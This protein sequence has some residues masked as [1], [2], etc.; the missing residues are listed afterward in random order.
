MSRSQ[1]DAHLDTRSSRLSR[2]KPRKA[3]YWSSL[4]VGLQ[5]GYFR[6]A[7]GPGT[8]RARFYSADTRCRLQT[9]LGTADD[10]AD[11]DGVLSFSFAQAQAKAREWFDVAHQQSTGEVIHRGPFT[12]TQAWEAYR[13]DCERRGIKSMDR[14]I[15]AVKLHILP[16]LGRIEVTKLT[17]LH[18]ERWH[19]ALA[20]ES[21]RM[22]PKAGEKEAFR[23][24]P[25][26]PNEVRAR[27]DSANRVLSI[28]KAMLSHAKARRLTQA[29][30]E[31]WRETRPFKGTT[32][33]RIRF[34]D[35][36]EA[37][38]L[39]NAADVDL[40]YLVQAALFTGARFGE[41]TRLQPRDFNPTSGTIFIAESKSGKPRHVVLTEEGQAFF[42]A[43][44][45]G[46]RADDTLFLHEGFDGRQWKQAKVLR[47]WK[48]SEQNRP[49]QAACA[50]AGLES[51]TF[52][53]LRH[54]YASL[55]INNGVPLAYVAAQLGHADT[56]MTE[57]HYGHLSP[58][59]LAEAIRTLAPKLG[60]HQPGKIAGLRILGA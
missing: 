33:S 15:G 52:H 31:A 39:V 16:A 37:Q 14:T 49:M 57:K 25:S 21:A 22:R 7:K 17:R 46:R 50:A 55:L 35:P 24:A 48:R 38:R 28:V 18:I 47:P 60:I 9:A 30:G 54:T 51:L 3:P 11:A 10:Y 26:T 5:L 53:E 36:D 29:S 1:R 20:K 27:R 34:L 2:L 32:S 59:A 6:P 13:L 40:R 8:W 41:L 43:M 56:R 42:R 58:S 45:I 23:P 12:V 19:E 4:G 44:V